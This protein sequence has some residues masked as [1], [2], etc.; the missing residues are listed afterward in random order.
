MAEATGLKVGKLSMMIFSAEV[1]GSARF[2]K[3]Y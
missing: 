2:L 3:D 1:L